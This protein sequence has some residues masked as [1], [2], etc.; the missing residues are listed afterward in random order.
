MTKARK[1]YQKSLDRYYDE[2]ALAD[3]DS[4]YSG[5]GRYRSNHFRLNT[6]LHLLE[7]MDPKPVDLLEAGCG[8]ARVILAALEN[9]YRCRGFD[10]SAGMLEAGTKRLA[11][12]GFDPGLI[13]AGDLYEVPY[14]DA[15]FD[16]VM[17]VGVIE[18]L[19]DH[20]RIFSEF[21][22]VLRPGGH[23]LVSLDNALFSLFSANAHTL[24][25]FRRLYDG[26][27]LPPD[28]ADL[29][30][31]FLAKG[32]D[33]D[34]VPHVAKCMEDA[35]IDKTAVAI[36]SDYNP[37]NLAERLKAFGLELEEL[38]FFHYHPLPPRFEK[39]RPELF[40]ALAE[41]LETVDYDWRGGI[42]C[43]AMLVQARK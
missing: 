9:G 35:E 37:L 42:L 7:R 24:K 17:C 38:R 43:N 40:D 6:I 30:L 26:I 20:Q 16:V 11:G 28:A 23:I 13:Q 36:D 18:N 2:K 19:P 22:R 3:Y 14:P 12:A 41:G 39:D 27:G 10:R 32:Y 34:H 1:D 15:S 29:H 25:F 5:K 4:T 33:V 21:R 31:S 8:D